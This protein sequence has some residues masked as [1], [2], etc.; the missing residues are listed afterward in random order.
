MHINRSIALLLATLAA[1]CAE[2]PSI[3]PGL[4]HDELVGEPVPLVRLQD[5]FA[6]DYSG[7]EAPARVVVESPV[8]WEIV[9]RR[10]WRN[11]DPVPATPSIDFD[12]EQ[13]LF[14]AMGGRPTGGYSVRV[15]AAAAQGDRVAVRVV[16]TSPGS[17]CVLTQATTAPIDIVKLPRTSKPIDFQTVKTVRE[18]D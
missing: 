7:F 1:G 14:V 12:R 16:E 18:C 15:T 9:W 4:H 5:P 11:H 13:V 17:G 6:I 10:I 3:A 8:E 2:L